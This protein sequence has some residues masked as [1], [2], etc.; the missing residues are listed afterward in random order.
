MWKLNARYL[1]YL[2]EFQFPREKFFK[3]S[4][5]EQVV[6][7]HVKNKRFCSYQTCGSGFDN[8]EASVPAL[9]QQKEYGETPFILAP[10]QPLAAVPPPGSLISR[11]QK[12]AKTY[13]A[14]E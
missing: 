1:V 12:A 10:N 9:T 7:Q 11:L 6:F 2:L 13:K 14:K 3:K 4:E 8:P 5:T